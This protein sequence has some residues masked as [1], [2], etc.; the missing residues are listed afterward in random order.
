MHDPFD[1]PRYEVVGQAHHLALAAGTRPSRRRVRSAST[2]SRSRSTTNAIPSAD[3]NAPAFE[4][5]V[6]RT[7]VA[8]NA[9]S[10][11]LGNLMSSDPS[12][13]VLGFDRD[14]CWRPN[15]EFVGVRTTQTSEAPDAVIQ[16]DL[17]D[18]FQDGDLGW[19]TL[20]STFRTP[21]AETHLRSTAVLRLGAWVSIR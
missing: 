17:V 13:R 3:S 6:R 5:V 21:E 11:A 1:D 18:A 15:A 7:I 2:D 9:G 10:E 12:L 16:V 19:A 4:S 20:F 8:Y 14:E